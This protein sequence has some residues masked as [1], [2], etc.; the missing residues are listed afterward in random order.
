MYPRMDNVADF[1]KAGLQ[2]EKDKRHID[3]YRPPTTTRKGLVEP[4]L[5]H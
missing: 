3:K 2:I 1:F 5:V 4:D